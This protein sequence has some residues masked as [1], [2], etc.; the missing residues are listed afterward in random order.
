LVYAA[1]WSGDITLTPNLQCPIVN[2]GIQT[3]SFSLYSQHSRAYGNPVFLGIL[4]S[5]P[6]PLCRARG[7]TPYTPQS[8]TRYTYSF[9]NSSTSTATID[10]AALQFNLSKPERISDEPCNWIFSVQGI[11]TSPII[12]PPYCAPGWSGVVGT[13]ALFYKKLYDPATLCAPPGEIPFWKALFSYY[14]P[15]TFES[16]TVQAQQGQLMS[17]G[18]YLNWNVGTVTLT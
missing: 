10:S 1:K 2:C 8:V 17:D 18:Y 15:S 12:A 6:N 14:N 3:Q 13:F 5:P 16:V 11:G 4:P 7:F 9:C